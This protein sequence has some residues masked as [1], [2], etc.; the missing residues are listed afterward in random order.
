M[1]TGAG[2][3]PASVRTPDLLALVS[4]PGLL[5]LA[6]D[7]FDRGT[8]RIYLPEARAVFRPG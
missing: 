3:A 4:A 6:A 5:T 8:L 7:V 2:A 1:A